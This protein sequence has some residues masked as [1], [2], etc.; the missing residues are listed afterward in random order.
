MKYIQKL[1]LVLTLLCTYAPSLSASTLHKLV[2]KNEI[3]KV[4]DFLKNNREKEIINAQNSYGKTPLY[5]ACSKNYKDIVKLLLENGA[6][7]NIPNKDKETPLYWA[8]A[9]GNLEIVKLLLEKDADVNIA[10]KN[11]ET[12]LYPACYLGYLDIVELLLKKGAKVN[13]PGPNGWPPLYWACAQ[14][15]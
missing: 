3:E 15:Y 12:P 4:K 14:D 1:S 8:C 7:P 11:R 10:N 13:I 2:K 9:K 6:N 5:Q